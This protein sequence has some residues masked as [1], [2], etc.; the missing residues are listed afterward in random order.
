MWGREI[1][2]G[3]GGMALAGAFTLALFVPDGEAGRAAT[4]LADERRALANAHAQAEAA[5]RRSE[6]LEQRATG[7][8][9]EAERA[10]NRAAAVAARIQQAEADLRAGQARIAIITALQAQQARRLAERQ[11]PIAR[12]VAGLQAITRRPPV[13]ALL[14]PGSIADA[15]HMRIVLGAALPVIAERT[16]GL[17]AELARSR[18]LRR[19]A[20]LARSALIATRGQ[21]TARR[22]EL[23]RLEQEKRVA[24]RQ[25]RDTAAMEADRALAMGED[26]R[27]IVDLMQ[28]MEDAGTVRAALMA[29]PG[30]V[31]RPAQPGE[32]PLPPVQRSAN[33]GGMGGYRLPVVGDIVAGFGE[34]QDNGVRSRGLTIA[35]APGAAVVAPANGRIA[36]AGP[37]RDFGAIVIIDH[38]GAWTSLVTHMRR[39]SVTVG[40][41]VRQGDPLGIAGPTRPQVTVELRR[42]DRP[43]DVAALLR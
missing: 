4:A 29:L 33:G 30:P 12:L 42:G 36:F 31:L 9:A 23:A 5:R 17:R 18:S 35:T 34:V 20:E 27:D 28:R 43:V 26:A 41:A 25:F 10:R 1:R 6:A 14:Q 39:L 19:D 21:L 7:A 2:I 8:D 3:V 15:V 22:A 37:F 16:A 40:E 32:A 38:G 11:A 24:S 13:L